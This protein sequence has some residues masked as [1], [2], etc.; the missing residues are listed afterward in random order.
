MGL[1]DRLSDLLGGGD[2][3]LAEVFD[4]ASDDAGSGSGGDAGGAG[5]DATDRDAGDMT[6]AEFRREAE[7]FAADHGDDYRLDFTVESLADVDEYAAGQ[8]DV[9]GALGEGMDDGE[10]LEQLDGGY[11]LWTGSYLG[12]VLVRSFDAEWVEDDGW[13]V[14]VPAD[15]GALEVAVFDIAAESVADEPLFSAVG[16]EV[17]E[18]VEGEGLGLAEASQ[19]AA[20]QETPQASAATELAEYWSEYDL[21]FSPASLARL[22]DLVDGQWESERFRDAELGGEDHVD[23]LTFTALVEQLGSYYGEVLVRTLDAGWVE[24]D[25]L[26]TAVEV[27]APGGVDDAAAVN[28]YHVAEDCLTEPSKF[29]VSFDTVVDQL[30]ID[31]EHVSEGGQV[32]TAGADVEA[33]DVPTDP[34]ALV[35]GFAE[36]ADELVERHPEYD[37]DYSPASLQ[38]LDRLVAEEFAD[39]EFQDVELGQE[40]DGDS[41]FLTAHAMEAGGYLAEVLDRHLRGGWRDDDGL[42][43]VV[44]GREAEAR[45]DPVAIAA[46]VFRGEDSF[47]ATYEALR[48]RLSVPEQGPGDDAG[49]PV[50]GETERLRDDDAGQSVGV[51]A[52]QPAGDA[53]QSVGVDAGQPAGDAGQSVGVDAGQSADSEAESSSG[54]PAPADGDAAPSGSAGESPPRG[55]AEALA[56][57]YDDRELEFTPRSLARLDELVAAHP[58][59]AGS[60]AGGLVAY[61]GETL[62]RSYGAEWARS[63]GDWVVDVGDDESMVLSLWAVVEDRLAGETTFAAVH[64]DIVDGLALDGP[65]LA[66]EAAPERDR[67]IERFA[68]RAAAET[69]AEQQAAPDPGGAAGRYRG[70]AEE[71]VAGWPS[72]E[73]DYTVESLVRLDGL[74]ADEFDESGGDRDYEGD[75]LTVPEGAQLSIPTDGSVE[76]FAGYL[77]ELFRRHH[78]AEWGVEDGDLVL[79]VEG[80]AGSQSFDPELVAVAC[81]AGESAFVDVYATVAA[82]AGLEPPISG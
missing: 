9:M 71:L 60:L 42:Y 1:L 32:V 65:T 44:Q 36:D 12:E 37:L 20:E 21:D 33:G 81:F 31:H 55:A 74:V 35:E 29:A 82:E 51:D 24:H 30:G 28:V 2:D 64:D 78:D 11:T 63:D 77:A 80:P 47:A 10:F 75:P 57:E 16:E 17:R 3:D 56:A 73:L 40:D 68:A 25:Q 43:F 66:T 62:V 38:R 23:D 46:D 19:A 69:A 39:H 34:E 54:E 15:G 14:E 50:G 26:G 53:G 70:A 5:T 76:G 7:A 52:G 13:A 22:D 6:A 67:T 45:L 4:S 8:G 79:A 49:Q 58:G 41:L 27:A 18:D 61:L 48:G 59:D 72:Y